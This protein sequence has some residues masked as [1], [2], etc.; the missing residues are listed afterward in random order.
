[1]NPAT[2]E[3]LANV[4]EAGQVRKMYHTCLFFLLF[5]YSKADIDAAVNAAKNAFKFDAPWRTMEPKERAN[6]MFKV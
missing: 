4:S 1:V 6:L 5:V 2:G 3:V